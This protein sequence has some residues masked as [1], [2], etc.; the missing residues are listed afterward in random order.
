MMDD[1]RDVT[2]RGKVHLSSTISDQPRALHP[3][4]PMNSH[5]TI[6]LNMGPGSMDHNEKSEN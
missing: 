3:K 6:I 5:V 2:E 1:I 4:F